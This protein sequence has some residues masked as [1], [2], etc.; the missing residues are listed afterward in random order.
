MKKY[1]AV[2]IVIPDE[3]KE[4]ED[5]FIDSLITDMRQ[6]GTLYAVKSIISPTHKLLLPGR[7][8]FTGNWEFT[9]NPLG[10]P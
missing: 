3:W 2:E 6:T 7:A 10:M 1:I 4:K 9:D 5:E 8:V